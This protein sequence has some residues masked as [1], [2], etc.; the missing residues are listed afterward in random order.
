MDRPVVFGPP[1]DRPI[2][3]TAAAWATVLLTLDTNDF[4]ALIENGFYH[5]PVMKPGVFLENE[6]E[7]GRLK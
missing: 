4:G 5:L 1:K 7:A 6:R 3:F 2:L